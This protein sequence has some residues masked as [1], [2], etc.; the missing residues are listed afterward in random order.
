MFCIQNNAV[1]DINDGTLSEIPYA[2]TEVGVVDHLTVKSVQEKGQSRALWGKPF[3]W[4]SHG[5]SPV[6]QQTASCYQTL[7]MCVSIHLFYNNKN[8][9]RGAV[10]FPHY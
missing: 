3:P 5:S 4:L 2:L 10:L 8:L 9:F 6:T 1:T 7:C